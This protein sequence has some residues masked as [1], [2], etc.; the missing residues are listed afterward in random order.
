[1]NWWYV[2]LPVVLLAAPLY[3]FFVCKFAGAG[4]AT[5]IRFA[6]RKRKEADGKVE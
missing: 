1:V 3:L 5:G 6:F 4:W 2:A